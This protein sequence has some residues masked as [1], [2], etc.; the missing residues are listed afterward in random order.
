MWVEAHLDFVGGSFA[1]VFDHLVDLLEDIF[2][3]ELGCAADFAESVGYEAQAGYVFFEFWYE[4]AGGGFF[5]EE[6]DPGFE[7]GDG[8]AELV[9]GFFGH[10]CPDLVLGGFVACGEGDDG[11][12]DEEGDYQQLYDGVVANFFE[13]HGFAIVDFVIVVGVFALFP[14]DGGVHGFEG[15]ELTG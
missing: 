5:F 8:G 4:F 3:F 10:A 14:D 15:M 7:G 13:Q 6:F 12:D 1:H 11:D 9:G 2:F